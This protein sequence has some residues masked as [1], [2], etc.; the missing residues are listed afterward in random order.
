MPVAAIFAGMVG[1]DKCPTTH[2]IKIRFRTSPI[3][4]TR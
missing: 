4:L 2:V 1:V 3:A